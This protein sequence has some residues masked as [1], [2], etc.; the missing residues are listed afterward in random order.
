M[1][2]ARRL[3]PVLLVMCA[4]FLTWNLQHSFA[5]SCSHQLELELVGA[6]RAR[7][8][9]NVTKSPRSASLPSSLPPRS[10]NRPQVRVG[11]SVLES[12]ARQEFLP[13]RLIVVTG[14]ESS[15]TTF[16]TE[17]LARAMGADADLDGGV[18]WTDQSHTVRIQH[19]SLPHGSVRENSE[20]YSRRFEPLP[21]VHVHVPDVCSYHSLPAGNWL[22]SSQPIPSPTPCHWLFGKTLVQTPARYF[23]NITSHIRFYRKVGVD[24]RAVLVV[25]DPAL[26][27]RGVLKAHCRNETAAMEQYRT[28]RTLLREAVKELESDELIIVSYETLMM[29]RKEYLFQIYENLN[30]ESD[31]TPEFKDGNVPH[32]SSSGNIPTYIENKL[33]TENGFS[34]LI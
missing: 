21:I 10:P 32:V 31:Y 27:F 20:E 7:I 34:D 14:L 1:V 24:A 30:I 23:V 8:A 11:D 15:G 16:V 3:P 28:G 4:G 2:F 17:V 12:A 29:L 18:E 33:K 25:R 9:Q 13:E 19:L 22:Q 6:I 5:P 26:R